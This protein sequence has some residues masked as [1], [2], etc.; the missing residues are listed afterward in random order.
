MGFDLNTAP[1]S[2]T[3]SMF[4]GICASFLLRRMTETLT[5]T[6]AA[7]ARGAKSKQV[8]KNSMSRAFLAADVQKRESSKTTDIVVKRAK[9]TPVHIAVLREFQFDFEN[10][11][12]ARPMMSHTVK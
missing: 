2:H 12:I 9:K 11:I 7:S 6:A 5:G 10:G 4:S 3:V 8:A 1:H